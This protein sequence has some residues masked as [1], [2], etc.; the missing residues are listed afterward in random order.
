M[1]EDKSYYPDEKML[2]KIKDEV[3]DVFKAVLYLSHKLNIDLLE[4]RSKSL[5]RWSKSIPSNQVREHLEIYR[6]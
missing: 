3:A 5:R 4:Q 6:V 1:S 2:Q